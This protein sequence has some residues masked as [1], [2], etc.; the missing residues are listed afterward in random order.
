MLTASIQKMVGAKIYN[1]DIPYT[2]I[3]LQVSIFMT[4]IVFYSIYNQSNFDTFISDKCSAV[5]KY[6]PNE[7]QMIDK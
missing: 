7:K 2:L 5:T 6:T 3:F 4:S 1:Q